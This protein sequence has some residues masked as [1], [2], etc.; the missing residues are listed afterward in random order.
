M[1]TQDIVNNRCRLVLVTPADQAPADLARRV[2]AAGRGGDVASVIVPQYGL[3]EDAYQALLEAVVPAGQAMGAAVIVAGEP[4]I[5]ARTGADG[6]HVRGDAAT[7]ARAIEAH[8][9][10]RIVGA[11]AGKSRHAA[12][13]VGEARPDYVL[14]GRLGADTHP[15]PHAGALE[16]AAW[17][18]QF[19]EVPAVV[20][21]GHDLAHLDRA[22][23]SGADFVALSRA[24]L[25]DG[26]DVEDAVR[27]ANAI[28]SHHV[29]A[30]AV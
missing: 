9:H 7:V 17:W 13:E 19:V 20:M 30:E 22:A 12:L 29:F 26:V 23:A 18:A 10:D 8:G 15:E 16:N 6:I 5:A 2:S 27:S 11:E 24:V 4:R 3:D 1:P 21:G 14:F 25:A 28:L